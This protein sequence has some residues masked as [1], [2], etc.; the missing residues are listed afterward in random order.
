M[1]LAWQI[2]MGAVAGML[3]A[4]ACWAVVSFT[5]SRFRP[6]GDEIHRPADGPALI[7]AGWPWW[8]IAAGFLIG[9]WVGWHVGTHPARRPDVQDARRVLD[10]WDV[11]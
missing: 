3:V 1:K 11:K 2:G 7:L 4:A 5:S 8:L 9:A 10:A 6:M